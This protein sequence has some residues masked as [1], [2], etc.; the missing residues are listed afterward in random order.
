[1]NIFPFHIRL[2]CSKLIYSGL[3]S[4]FSK[5]Y[6]KTGKICLLFLSSHVFS[7]LEFDSNNFGILLWKIV[8]LHDHNEIKSH[9][10]EKYSEIKNQ[11]DIILWCLKKICFAHLWTKF[12]TII[13]RYSTSACPC[14]FNTRSHLLS[15][16]L[17]MLSKNEGIFFGVKIAVWKQWPTMY[18]LFVSAYEFLLKSR[19]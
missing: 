10:S 17:Q 18:I 9:H 16:W 12:T 15:K 7:T 8:K 3:I 2:E 4:N 6:L 5:Y 1:M 14:S 13:T 11:I 19:T